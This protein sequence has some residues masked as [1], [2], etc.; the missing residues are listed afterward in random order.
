[1]LAVFPGSFNPITK[2]HLNLIERAAKLYDSLIVVV[3]ESGT[4]NLSA[5]DRASIVSL[6]CADISNVTVVVSDELLVNFA[7][8]NGAKVI[9]RGVRSGDDLCYENNMA[10]MNS[11]LGDGIETLLLPAAPEYSHISSTL[12]RQVLATGGN[13]EYFVPENVLQDMLDRGYYGTKNN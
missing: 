13:A 4:I 8:R 2:G 7:R 3:N 12:V 11:I 10:N 9:V 1:M 6:A 5:A